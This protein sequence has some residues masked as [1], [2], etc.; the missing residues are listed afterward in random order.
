[1]PQATIEYNLGFV[2][3]APLEALYRN[4]GRDIVAGMVLVEVVMLSKLDELGVTSVETSR[5]A[6]LSAARATYELHL[7]LEFKVRASIEALAIISKNTIGSP[8]LPPGAVRLNESGWGGATYGGRLRVGDWVDWHQNIR[9][10]WSG[11]NQRLGSW[12]QEN[13]APR[14][15]PLVED[16]SIIP[17]R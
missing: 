3:E 13:S 1:V 8:Q 4:M 6:Y 7:N 5:T 9:H 12:I 17:G 15:W 11:Y 14:S 16:I 10:D 2:W